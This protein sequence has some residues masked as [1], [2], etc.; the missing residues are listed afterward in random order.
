V[1]FHYLAQGLASNPSIDAALRDLGCGRS[2]SILDMPRSVYPVLLSAIS[3]STSTTILVITGRDDRAMDLAA[4]TGEYLQAENSCI[5]WPAP[6]SLPYERLPRD[7]HVSAQRVRTLSEMEQDENPQL[8]F[9]SVAG[10]TQYVLSPNQLANSRLMVKVGDRLDDRE[11][12]TW[13]IEHGYSAEAVVNRFGTFSR[14]GGLIDLFSPASSLPLRIEFF[15]DEV[16]SIRTFDPET[17]R[18]QQ[19]LQEA[20]LLPP[21]ELPLNLAPE[22]ADLLNELDLTSLREEVEEEWRRS[23][24]RLLSRTIP[25]GIDLFAPYLLDRPATLLSY[26]ASNSLL[27]FDAPESIELVAKQRDSH[28]DELLSTAVQSGELTPGLRRPFASWDEISQS[29]SS[30]HRVELGPSPSPPKT[31]HVAADLSAAP[32]F[33]GRLADLTDEVSKLLSDDWSITLATDQ[34]DRLTEIFEAESIYPLREK[35]RRGSDETQNIAGA[36][37]IRASDLDGGWLDAASKLLLLTD[38][39][40]F[41]FRKAVRRGVDRSRSGRTELLSSLT[42]GYYVVHIDHGIARFSGLVRVEQGGVE[43]EYLL[44]EYA[45]GDKLYVPVDQSHRVSRYS[46][47]ALEPALNRLGSGEWAR[48]KQRVRRS[49]REMAYELVRLYASRETN[50]GFA[51]GPDTAWDG[52][53]AESFPYTE[54]VDQLK[55]IDDVRH[56][57]MSEKPMDRLVCGDV[58]FGK[59]EVAIRGA[60]KAVNAGKQVAVLVPTTVLALQHYATFCQRLAPFPVSI[61]M[62]SRLR[63]PAQQRDVIER[64][65][66]GTVDIVIGTH[67]LVQRDV[68]F[69]DLGLVVVDEE[70]R[71][72]VR[73]KEFLKQLRSEVDVLTMSAT[74]IPRTLHISMAGIRDISLIETAPQARLPIRTFVT[75]SNENLIR[76]AIL[77]ELDRGGQVYFVHNRVSSIGQLARKLERLVPEARF[78]VGHGQMDEQVL[79]DVI[80]GFIRHDFDVLICTTIIESGVDI[81]NVNTIIIDNADTLGLTQLYQLRGRVGRSTNR[82]YAYLLYREGKPLS[83]EAESRLEAIQEATELGA[84]IQVAMRDMEIRGA[85]NLLGAEQSGHIAEI[86][87]ELYVRLLSQ[88]VDEIKRG[89]PIRDQ[90]AILLDLPLTALIPA[91]YVRDVELRLTLYRRIAA[92]DSMAGLS[93]LRRELI[94]RF[95]EIPTEVEHLLALIVLRLR[96]EELGIESIVEREREIVIRPVDTTR[97][98]RHGLTR[99]VGPALKLTPHSIRIRLPQLEVDWEKALNV[100]LNEVEQSQA[101]T[102]ASAS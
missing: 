15:G 29:L 101:A 51:F 89:E 38:L 90:E 23:I 79:E 76:E 49:V 8:I 39:E 44:L 63:T 78:G 13:A 85:G 3:G 2:L 10:L 62:L 54:T 27:I 68:D 100:I 74:P 42:Q 102:L 67:R 98:D 16:D 55:A 35:R 36:V 12:V 14:R 66:E 70:Q 65:R 48:T 81:P 31:A 88:A 58:G 20:I 64:L 25:A 34:V 93:E 7:E 87:Y 97:I 53:L 94:D 75:R 86:G 33:A 82:A 45:K 92:I 91:N 50:P 71:F 95:G 9:T 80:L 24:D 99:K 19:R 72:G 32:H 73:Q 17:Q 83:A 21:I 1:S 56:D 5:L 47:G 11:L 57:M 69:K 40:V 30:F 77:R 18:S 6:E 46:S 52:E 37:Q 84:G 26:L 60:F 28:G 59:T 43:R 41:G 4:S 96:C 61:E 22:A